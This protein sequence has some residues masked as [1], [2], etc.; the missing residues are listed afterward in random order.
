MYLNLSSI[1]LS[2][3]WIILHV[4]GFEC[5]ATLRLLG[6]MLSN[7]QQTTNTFIVRPLSANTSCAWQLVAPKYSS[8][9]DYWYSPSGITIFKVSIVKQCG[10]VSNPTPPRKHAATL[11][12]L[13]KSQIFYIHYSNQNSILVNTLNPQFCT[14]ILWRFCYLHFY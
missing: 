10:P 6:F 2:L 8:Y 1:V 12:I 4:F 11:L 5:E 3:P 7:T 14:P 9:S 13:I